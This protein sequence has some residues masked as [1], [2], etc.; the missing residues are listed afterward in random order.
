MHISSLTSENND[1]IANASPTQ[2]AIAY[3]ECKKN[4]PIGQELSLHKH[5]HKNLGLN[6][7]HP[8]KKSSLG[9]GEM[10]HCLRAWLL[11]QRTKL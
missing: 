3:R 10:A 2:E 5:N 9:T 7:D 4:F 8:H 6:P 11:L 1:S